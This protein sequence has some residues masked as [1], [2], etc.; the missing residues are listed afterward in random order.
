MAKSNLA[1]NH[2]NYSYGYAVPTKKNSSNLRIKSVQK[3]TTVKEN[4]KTAKVIKKNKNGEKLLIVV[5]AALAFMMLVRGVAITKR[6]DEISAK[7]AELEKLQTTNQKMQ[8]EIDSAL[9]LKNVEEIAVNELNMSR[10]EKHQTVYIKIA[11]DDVVEKTN[12]SKVKGA[13]DDF[14]GTVKAYLD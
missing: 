5:L 3:Q 12:S 14:F 6:H 4:K 10:P 11:Q 13:I 8:I 1:Y 2:E 7:K 9:N